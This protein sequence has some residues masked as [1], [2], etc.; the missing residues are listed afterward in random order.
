MEVRAALRW[1]KR[2]AT[3][4]TQGLADDG[5]WRDPQRR[6]SEDAK[7]RSLRDKVSWWLDQRPDWLKDLILIKESGHNTWDALV[8]E[9]REGTSSWGPWPLKALGEILGIRIHRWEI[10]DG[11]LGLR[12]TSPPRVFMARKMAEEAEQKPKKCYLKA[13][14]Q[15][16]EAQYSILTVTLALG[17]Q[18]LVEHTKAA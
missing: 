10:H 3:G 18:M 9:I 15:G 2:S 6:A 12:E 8:D 7:V 4:G 11:G 1:L 16:C 13:G 5:R 14:K 17:R